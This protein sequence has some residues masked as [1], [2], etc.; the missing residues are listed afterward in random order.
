MKFKQMIRMQEV[1]ASSMISYTWLSYCT[2]SGGRLQMHTR[3]CLPLLTYIWSITGRRLSSRRL[4]QL[5]SISIIDW[6]LCKVPPCRLGT[7]N[8]SNT[9][10]NLN[11]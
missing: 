6:S 10:L 3:V 11:F 5:V 4:N 8:L 1:N 9:Y 2:A 7:R